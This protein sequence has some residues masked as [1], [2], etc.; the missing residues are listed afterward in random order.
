[1]N[2]ALFQPDIAANAAAAIRL[3]A[4]FGT[5]V[6]I[7]EPCGFVWD[8]RRL[9]RVGMD[10]VDRA[11]IRRWPSWSRFEEARRE[12]GERLVLLTT[13]AEL[14][15]HRFDFRAGD[16]LLGGRESA[17]VPDEVHAAAD[18]RIHL[19]MAPGM[20]SL[21][22]VTAL[23]IVLGE[24]LRQ[25]GGFPKTDHEPLDAGGVGDRPR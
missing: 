18:I 9:R 10:Y 25:T 15:Y 20:R 24:A 8:D 7:I 4:C 5:P 12:N 11:V 22:L 14:S 13:R 1:M 2:I 6:S 21:N 3:G 23:S 17:G 16:I 19:P